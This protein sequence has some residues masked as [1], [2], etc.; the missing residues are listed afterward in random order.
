MTD[1]LQGVGDS[2]GAYSEEEY[3][4]YI[5]CDEREVERRFRDKSDDKINYRRD[6]ELYH[7]HSDTVAPRGEVVNGENVD[8]ENYSSYHDENVRRSH[9]EI[10]LDAEKIE[11]NHSDDYAHPDVYGGFFL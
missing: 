3:G 6:E 11:S 4:Q 1:Y 2:A 8:R 7:R 5:V 9:G 10:L